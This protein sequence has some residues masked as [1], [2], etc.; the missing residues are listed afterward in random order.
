[1]C[2]TKLLV[3]H[4]KGVQKCPLCQK[5]LHNFLEYEG[6][7]FGTLP[8]KEQTLNGAAYSAMLKDKLKPATYHKRRG[9][10]SKTASLHHDNVCPY[11]MVA[12]V[13]T[14]HNLK[15]EVLPHPPYSPD[16]IPCDFHAFGPLR[17]VLHGYWFGSDEKEKE[18]VCIWIREQPKTFFS[19]GIRKL[20]DCLKLC[21]AAW[22]WVEE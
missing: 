10:L 14:I 1:V 16:L 3:L 2:L 12:T 7:Y 20:V 21:G 4:G 18:V 5:K 15:F 17:E 19:D 11:V 9:L 13:E 8:K 6:S 22:R